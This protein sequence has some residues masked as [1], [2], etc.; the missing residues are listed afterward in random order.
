MV[1]EAGNETNGP[2][3]GWM[4][5]YRDFREVRWIGLRGRMGWNESGGSG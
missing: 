5:T 2:E 4:D 3:N 1:V